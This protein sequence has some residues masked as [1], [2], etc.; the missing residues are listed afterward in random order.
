MVMFID[1]PIKKKCW[2]LYDSYGEICV[3]CGCCSTDKKT[4]YEARLA[5]LKEWLKEQEEFD[6]WYYEDHDTLE[7]QKKNVKANIKYFKRRIRYYENI[8]KGLE[9]N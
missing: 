3:H 4:R 5:C 7:L 1:V 2:N 9:N 6:G 8:L